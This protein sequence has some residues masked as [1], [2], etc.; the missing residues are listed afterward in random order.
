MYPARCAARFGIVSLTLTP[1]A[2]WQAEHTCATLAFPASMSAALQIGAIPA[3]T[4]RT[5]SRF[6][7]TS[8]LVGS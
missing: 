8:P 4:S 1:L 6:I 7:E 5:S 2:P 3:A